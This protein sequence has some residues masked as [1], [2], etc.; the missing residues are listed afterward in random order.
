LLISRPGPLIVTV[1]LRV[2]AGPEPAAGKVRSL[3]RARVCVPARS[4]VPE[5][6]SVVFAPI[7]VVPPLIVSTMPEA[8][9]RVPAV[10]SKVCPALVIFRGEL[11]VRVPRP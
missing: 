9:P 7:R 5:P 2:S 1:P 3:A 4:I 8:M 6:D 10:L 11:M